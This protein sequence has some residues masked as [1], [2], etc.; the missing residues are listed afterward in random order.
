MSNKFIPNSFQVPNVLVDEY[1]TELSSH[2]FKLLMFIIRKTKGFQKQKDTISTTQLA[3]VLGVK[4]LSNVYRYTKELEALHLIKTHKS[5]GKTN[6]FSLGK[7]FTKPVPKKV[8]TE[9]ESSPKKGEYPVPNT[10]TGS[11]P[12]KGDSTKDINKTNINK[13]KNI[14][15]E[16]LIDEFNEDEKELMQ[17]LIDHREEISKPLKTKR[18]AEM[19]LKKLQHYAREWDITFDDALDFWLGENWQS[20][21][22]SYD[23]PFRSRDRSDDNKPQKGTVASMNPM[24]QSRINNSNKQLE[25]AANYE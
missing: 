12:K 2:S 9:S 10:G 19:L 13:E 14:Q 15:K 7:N 20:I 11:S 6:Q 4:K 3:K 8:T 5:L 23:Y 22:V 25:K 21:D 24:Q 18:A 17:I 1:I 16:N